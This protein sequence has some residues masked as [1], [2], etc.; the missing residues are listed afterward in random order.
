MTAHVA[1]D[2]AA[3]AARVHR[4]GRRA[5]VSHFDLLALADFVVATLAEET[6]VRASLAASV[7]VVLRGMDEWQAAE[8]A[9][10]LAHD[11]GADDGAADL[12]AGDAL[13]ELANSLITLKTVFEQEFPNG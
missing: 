6:P 1:I 8:A 9:A 5:R 2:V 7:A 4:D 12:S 3:V 13:C 10:Q 11:Q